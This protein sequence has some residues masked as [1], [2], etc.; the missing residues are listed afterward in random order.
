MLSLIL[1]PSP[2]SSFLL[3]LQPFR[4]VAKR[5]IS[6]NISVAMSYEPFRTERPTAPLHD[7]ALKKKVVLCG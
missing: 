1:T 6:E 2:M 5:H 7:A 3:K 4:E